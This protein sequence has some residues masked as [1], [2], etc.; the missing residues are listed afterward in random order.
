MKRIGNYVHP[1]RSQFP[2][3]PPALEVPM[4]V[5]GKQLK[6]IT[7]LLQNR[8]VLGVNSNDEDREFECQHDTDITIGLN[9]LKG[10]P[11]GAIPYYS[12]AGEVP[13]IRRW[14]VLNER[15]IKMALFF[16]SAPAG[17]VTVRMLIRGG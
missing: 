14:Q 1:T 8:F 2:G 9:T 17:K 3:I 12:S 16:D 4:R 5:Q 6:D 11:R 7:E 15:S 13:R 10:P